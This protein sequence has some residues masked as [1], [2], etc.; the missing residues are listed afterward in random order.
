MPGQITLLSGFAELSQFTLDPPSI[1]LIPRAFAR[2][3]AL[4]VLGAVDPKAKTPVRL[5]AAYPERE[6]AL[7]EAAELLARPVEVVRLNLYEIDAVLRVGYDGPAAARQDRDLR[8]IPL[9]MAQ[10][11]AEASAVLLVD[12]LLAGAVRLGASDIHLE[13]YPE[14]V[15]LRYR[16]DGILQQ[17]Y[18]HASP[19]N[20]AEIVS[21]IKILAELDI[22]EKRRPQDGR[23]RIILTEG[24]RHFPVDFRVSVVPSPAGEDVVLRV[25]DP[26]QG[27]LTVHELGMA[28]AMEETFSRMLN[29]PEGLLL[30]TGPTSSGK[31][32]TLYSALSQ[33]SDQARKII[34]A[35]DP[36]EYFLDRINQKQV[37]E[38]M[39]YSQLLRA[40]LR[41][42]PD[43]VLVGEL[44]DLESASMA[45]DAAA[46]GHLVL[47]TL[48]T[49]DA[50]GVVT[51]LRGIGVDDA[52]QASALLGAVGQRLVRRLC[53]SCRAPAEVDEAGRRLF[54]ALL[55]GRTFFTSY[56]C[57]A[58]R[59]TGYKGRVGIYELLM[60]D[61]ALQDQIAQGAPRHEIRQWC[62]EQGYR[63]MT[64][65]ALDKAAAGVTSLA[66]LVRVLPYRQISLTRQDLETGRFARSRKG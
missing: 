27:L 3:N 25:L 45:L 53:P 63:T 18:T 6:D 62:A 38:Q 64:H 35:E 56:G 24:T 2:R 52:D 14:D 37:T 17:V 30:V 66:E 51:R 33:I 46:T 48:H 20:I 42:N 28:P 32:T 49:S 58:C 22:A 65:D 21:R 7:R 47:G 1:R 8:V 34:T 16:V 41:Q 31:T 5:G 19:Q 12:H 44:R 15:D 36:I 50:I 9:Q 59:N 10:P 55:E 29:N 39:S 40:M 43:V 57:K 61:E 26:N 4:A 11:S 54:G 13:T 23:F 60:V